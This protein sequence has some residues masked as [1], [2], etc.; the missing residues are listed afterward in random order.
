MRFEDYTLVGIDR[1][2]RAIPLWSLG[3]K[4]NAKQE[5]FLENINWLSNLG[6]RTSYGT[7]GSVPLAGYVKRS[8][9]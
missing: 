8:F 7:G 4:W 3:L 5:S 9:Q 6:I 2:N 1:K